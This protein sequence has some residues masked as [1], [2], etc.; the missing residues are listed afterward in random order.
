L[1]GATAREHTRKQNKDITKGTI[2]FI[3]TSIQQHT[4]RNTAVSATRYATQMQPK[5][6]F[7]GQSTIK[8]VP[9]S[10]HLMANPMTDLA[11]TLTQIWTY[12]IKSCAAVAHETATMTPAGLQHDRQWLIIDA[13]GRFQTQRQ[14]PHLVWIEPQVQ[15]DTLV[16]SAPDMPTIELPF[17]TDT[18]AK[19]TVTIW[20]DRVRALDMGDAAAQWLDD[21][22]GV[23]TRQFRLVE[24]DANSQRLSDTF[25]CGNQSATVQFADGF[26][27]NILSQASLDHFNDRLIAFGA[28]PVDVRRFR[29]NLVVSGL[30]VH[31]EDQVHTLTFNA[32]GRSLLLEMVK[33]CPRCQIPAIN[34]F[35][36]NAEPEISTVLASYRQ[37]ASMDHA[38]C[39]AMNAVVRSPDTW[40]LRTHDPFVANLRFD[41]NRANRHA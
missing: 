37:Q 3:G 27:V 22:L 20:G 18:S 31:E 28:E 32:D 13:D 16:I 29:P 17:A 4:I 41:G 8:L 25:W 30:D 6:L 26:A 14:F 24:F 7:F 15:Q 1:T 19:R 12:P 23:P 33:P 11:G 21:Y 40:T 10:N 9:R 34:P 39:F 38:V 35:T 2:Q 36:A 5:R